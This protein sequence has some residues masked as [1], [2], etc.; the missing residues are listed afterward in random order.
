MTRRLG[1]IRSALHLPDG[2][3]EPPDEPPFEGL[4][5]WADRVCDRCGEP[6]AGVQD[7]CPSCRVTEA[8]EAAE[9]AARDEA[10]E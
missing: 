2:P 10:A 6:M 8:G 5:A 3:L 7:L 9:R 1:T 4:P